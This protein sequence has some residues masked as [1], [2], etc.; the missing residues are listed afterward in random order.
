VTPRPTCL[1]DGCSKPASGV[2]HHPTGQ[3]AAGA[4]LDPW[5]VAG[6]CH[7][8]HMLVHDDWHTHRVADGAERSTF[9]EWLELCLSRVAVTVGRL[10]GPA[11]QDPLRIFLAHLAAWLARS[12]AGLSQAIDALDRTCPAWRTSP[13]V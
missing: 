9:L 13:D 1:V 10:A 8:H 11:P 6:L 7:S 3:N 12:G 2:R 5:F 4:H